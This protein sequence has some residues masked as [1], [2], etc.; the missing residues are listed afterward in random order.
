MSECK[1]TRA[2]AGADADA[3][4][5]RRA[6]SPSSATSTG[7]GS[8]P[9][10][11]SSSR[12]RPPPPRLDSRHQQQFPSPPVTRSSRPSKRDMP[13]VS[14]APCPTTTIRASGAASSAIRDKAAAVRSATVVTG[15]PSGGSQVASSAG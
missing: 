12:Q 5:G 14:E 13:Q 9:T 3:G 10:L 4:G 7:S 8:A 2:G 11:Y 15:S 1:Q 6:L